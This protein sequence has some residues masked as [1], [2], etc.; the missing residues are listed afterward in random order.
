MSL[1]EI[2]Q[3]FDWWLSVWLVW[4]LSLTIQSLGRESL[5]W[6]R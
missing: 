1:R 3:I 4:N 2:G 5:Y 6:L